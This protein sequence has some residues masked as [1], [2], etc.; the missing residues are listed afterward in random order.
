MNFFFPLDEVQQ[1]C[2][3]SAGVLLFPF[4]LSVFFMQQSLSWLEICNEL[5]FSADNF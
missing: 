2:V 1:G 5:I 4:Y 3:I